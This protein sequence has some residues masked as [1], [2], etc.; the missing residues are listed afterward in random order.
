MDGLG[1]DLAMDSCRPC[2]LP[3]R[4]WV[5]SQE[6]G[7]FRFFT[8]CF[9]LLP[10]GFCYCLVV[11]DNILRH[12][13]ALGISSL[14]LLYEQPEMRL[15]LFPFL[16]RSSQLAFNSLFEIVGIR[17]VFAFSFS[18][19]FREHIS[20]PWQLYCTLIVLDFRSF[21]CW[22]GTNYTYG[23]FPTYMTN[24]YEV[25]SPSSWLELLWYLASPYPP[26]IVLL[27]TLWDMVRR[28]Y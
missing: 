28:C 4:V 15:F 23:Q 5:L 1:H 17:S 2:I 18:L 25:G 11:V 9:R 7:P 16:W 14:T 19:T 26:P 13:R 22:A 24:C 10:H 6:P 27:C 20:A 8:I 21:L 3:S 12:V